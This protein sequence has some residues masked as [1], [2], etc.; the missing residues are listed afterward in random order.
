MST[1]TSPKLISRRRIIPAVLGVLGA[2]AA[3]LAA[4]TKRKTAVKHHTMSWVARDDGRLLS[5]QKIVEC[6]LA[7]W[8]ALKLRDPEYRS[9]GTH[10]LE[11]STPGSEKRLVAISAQRFR[12]EV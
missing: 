4:A 7:E 12:D 2:P 1:T 9:W 11:S 10:R 8:E 5:T 6:T 3:L